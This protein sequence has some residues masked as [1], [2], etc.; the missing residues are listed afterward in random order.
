MGINPRRLNALSKQA[1]VL[2]L[3]FLLLPATWAQAQSASVSVDVS[4]LDENTYERMDALSLE[5]KVIVRLIQEG[6]AVVATSEKPHI[7]VTYL[8]SEG[9][10]INVQ[11]GDTNLERAVGISSDP[12]LDALHLEVA[13]KTVELVRQMPAPTSATPATPNTP[14]PVPAEVVAIEPESP[15][16]RPLLLGAMA[17]FVFRGESDLQLG[18]Q[19]AYPF[20]NA[21]AFTGT[22]NFVPASSPDI[23]VFEWQAQAGLSWTVLVTNPW[24]LEVGI[25]GGVLVHHFSLPNDSGT[26]VSALV[27]IPLSITRTLKQG[28]TLGVRLAPGFTPESRE[29]TA[30]GLQLWQRSGAR[31]EV[32]GYVSWQL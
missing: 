6:F 26:R 3:V 8:A 17:G 32:V 24:R 4:Q 5:H 7:R 29:H 9:L 16:H 30:G 19:L 13:Q 21:L 12:G 14:V 20:A 2:F 1:V 31:L 27:T 15:P 23:D 25:S 18:L 22:V 11:A 28:P 10:I